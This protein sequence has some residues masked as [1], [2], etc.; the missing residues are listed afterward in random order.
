MCQKS[1]QLKKKDKFANIKLPG[2]FSCVNKG[3]YNTKVVNGLQ[4]KCVP[5]FQIQGLMLW[6]QYAFVWYREL[7]KIRISQQKIWNW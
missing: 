1:L 2:I 4:K 5:K 6:I 7:I 3:E